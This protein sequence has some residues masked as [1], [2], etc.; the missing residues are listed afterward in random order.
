M[1]GRLVAKILVLLFIFTG[2]IFIVNKI[3]NN[4]VEEVSVEMEQAT[5]PI[6]YVRYKE[7]YKVFKRGDIR[8]GDTL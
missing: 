4:G 6:V 1:D 7:T 3:N 8:K 5:L 2:T